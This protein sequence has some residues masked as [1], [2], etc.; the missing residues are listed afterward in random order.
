MKELATVSTESCTTTG[1]CVHHAVQETDASRS[2]LNYASAT[3]DPVPNL[4]D[5]ELPLL[6]QEGS[7]RAMTFQAAPVDRALG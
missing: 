3:G 5:Q 2:G 6:T 7:L 4:G 1:R